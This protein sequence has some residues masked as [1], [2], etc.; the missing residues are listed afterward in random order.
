[1]SSHPETSPLV[2]GHEAAP[3]LLAE[4]V[5]HLDAM[6]AYWDGDQRCRFANRAYKD[7]FGRGRQE[8]MGISLRE[9]L[10]PLYEMN[11][12]H[13][14]AAYRGER[15]V[16]ERAIPRPDGSGVRH[17]LA[18]Y[19]PRVVDGQVLGMFVHV[20]DVEPLKRLEL[21]LKAA[22]DVAEAL[23]LHDPLTGLP[24]RRLL[25]DRLTE[26]ILRGKRTEERVYVLSIDVDHFKLVN[27][28]YGHAGG[29]RL[30]IEFAA[31]IKSCMRDYDTVARIGGDE[32]LVLVADIAFDEGI[33]AL[34]AR[35]LQTVR[36]PVSIDGAV[37]KPGLSVGIAEFPRHGLTSDSLMLASDR[38]LYAAKR[39]GR[40]C[41]RFADGDALAQP[42]GSVSQKP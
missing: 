12:P 19:M 2:K 9:L 15:Q 5:E 21:Q 28:T 16:F 20:A 35:L 38:A 6:V 14:E 1:M 13:I 30:L 22:R 26:A 41:F 32:F 18:T 7:W 29:D 10:G 4:L 39:A 36:Q 25:Q 37:L 34:V 11:L 24:N 8:L 17:S 23:A 31:R 27:D 3:A 40:N 33:E 42:S